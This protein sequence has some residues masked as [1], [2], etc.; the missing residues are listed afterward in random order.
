MAMVLAVLTPLN[1]FVLQVHI[2]LEQC[3]VSSRMHNAYACKYTYICFCICMYV[4]MYVLYALTNV[5]MC[6][7][8]I[9][10]Y[11]Y[12]IL[13]YV[14]M[15]I[16]TI[17]KMIKST[18]KIGWANPNSGN[19]TATTLWCCQATGIEGLCSR[20]DPSLL[21]GLFTWSHVPAT[22]YVLSWR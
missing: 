4:C 13:L 5:C 14:Y 22:V 17:H 3:V 12:Y 2:I 21:W 18:S 20:L 11:A 1:V 8:Y 7:Y 15:Y 16:H 19:T 9:Y 6:A 10:I